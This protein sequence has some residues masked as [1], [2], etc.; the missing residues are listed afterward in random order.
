MKKPNRAKCL[1]CN[2]VITSK[3]VHDFVE[4]SCGAIFVDG[5]DEYH[6]FGW[7]DGK[8]FIAPYDGEA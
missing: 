2:D 6:R 7:T 5:G 3:S 1:E 4:C 8:A